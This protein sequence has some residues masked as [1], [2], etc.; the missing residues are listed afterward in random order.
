M[1]NLRQFIIESEAVVESDPLVLKPRVRTRSAIPRKLWRQLPLDIQL[2]L[3]KEHQYNHY[4]SSTDSIESVETYIC[5][6]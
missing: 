5:E 6:E 1:T 2:L 4:N 3:E